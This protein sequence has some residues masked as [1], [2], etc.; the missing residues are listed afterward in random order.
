MNF[1]EGGGGGGSD[2]RPEKQPERFL[3]FSP[4]LILQLTEGVKWFYYRENYTF[5]KIERESN[6][7]QGE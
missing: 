4:Q 7:F 5:P 6:I 1:C 2:R 3:F